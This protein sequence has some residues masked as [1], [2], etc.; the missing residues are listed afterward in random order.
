MHHS[1]KEREGVGE[2]GKEGDR[3]EGRIFKGND[4]L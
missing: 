3:E 2:E 4:C 1:Q